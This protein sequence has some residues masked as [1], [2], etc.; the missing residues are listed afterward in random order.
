MSSDY[1]DDVPCISIKTY[2]LKVYVFDY[3]S[4]VAYDFICKAFSYDDDHDCIFPE[5]ILVSVDRKLCMVSAF[6]GKRAYDSC[7]LEKMSV[8]L[9]KNFGRKVLDSYLLSYLRLFM[10]KRQIELCKLD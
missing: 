2:Q 8:S 3:L 9:V 1:I 7:L 6:N 5:K 4:I 10:T